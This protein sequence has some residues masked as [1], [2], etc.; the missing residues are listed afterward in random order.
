MT[1]N[2]SFVDF[3]PDLEPEYITTDGDIAWVTLQEN[4][5][6]AM[7]NIRNGRVKKVFALG[8][9]DRSKARNKLDG[10]DEDGRINIARWPVFGM[11]QPDALA[12]FKHDDKRYLITVNE[13]DARD[14][15]GFAEEERVG[16]TDHD[17]DFD[18]LYVPRGRSFSIW[19][20]S[21]GALVFDS[22]AE[23]EQLL[24]NLLPKEFNSNH[25]QNDSFGNRSDNKG[26][27][28][29][30]VTLGKV[31]GRLYAFV[32]LERIDGILVLDL[33]DPKNPEF[34]ELHGV[35][36]R[37]PFPQRS[38]PGVAEVL[39][40]RSGPPSQARGKSGIPC[41]R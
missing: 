39:A 7:L 38:P 8:F 22:G 18:Q 32:G 11:Y 16:D 27:E 12:V 30:G 17:G 37:R 20:A 41:C 21:T 25:E 23:L 2:V 19:N 6:I 36:G 34:V 35:S 29:A 26:P 13:G 28:P 10:G 33:S 1:I 9:K 5:A 14:C 4:N 3:A 40:A 31:K 15:D 24:A